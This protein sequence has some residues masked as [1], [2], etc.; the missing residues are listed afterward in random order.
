MTKSV[1][2]TAMPRLQLA[3]LSWQ[4]WPSLQQKRTLSHFEHWHWHTCTAAWAQTQISCCPPA[5]GGECGVP[6]ETLFVNP[7]TD[8]QTQWFSVDVGPVHFLQLSSGEL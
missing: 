1:C 8:R 6:Y 3:A 4:L 7:S 5:D 2:K